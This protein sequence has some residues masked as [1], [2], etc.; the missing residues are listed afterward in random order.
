ML[1]MRTFRNLI[2]WRK[3]LRFVIKIYCL[4]KN[5]PKHET[6]GLTVQL[7][8]CALSIPSNIAEGYG[9]NSKKEFKRYLQ[10]AMGSLFEL[11]TQLCVAFGLKYIKIDTYKKM[12]ADSREIERMLSSLISKLSP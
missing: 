8:R 10:I 11:Q 4:T 3:S 9:R 5:F 2:V 7:H 1:I 6:Y 12:T